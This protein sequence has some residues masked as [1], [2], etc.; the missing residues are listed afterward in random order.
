MVS[1]VL[2]ALSSFV[3]YAYGEDQ[4]EAPVERKVCVINLKKDAAFLTSQLEETNCEAGDVLY[5]AETQLIGFT[6]HTTAMVSAQV[7]DF[8]YQ[9]IP[10]SLQ[11]T[12]STICIFSGGVLQLGGSRDILKAGGFHKNPENLHKLIKD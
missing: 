5:F 6:Q 3:G 12:V 10:F 7:C 4:P 8:R 1:F 2:M 9:V 11:N